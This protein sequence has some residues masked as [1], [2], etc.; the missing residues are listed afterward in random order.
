MRRVALLLCLGM[1]CAGGRGAALAAGETFADPFAYCA[2]VGT[3]DAPDARYTGARMPESI[4]RGLKQAL[5]APAGA[6]L[7]PF[8][9]HSFW[10]CMDGQVYAC[11]V[12]ANIPC[13]E[14]ADTSGTPTAA[15]ADFCRS[16]PGQDVIRVRHRPRHRLPLALRR[17]HPADRPHGHHR[18][19]AR[20]SGERLASDPAARI[21]V[22]HCAAPPAIVTDV[23]PRR[24]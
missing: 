24:R 12:G 14:K 22:R 11:T 20:L 7:T 21:R 8:L 13:Q 16:R 18:R 15:M 19:P 23:S 2:A 5:G 3:I 9:E 17:R 10:R 1:L 6:P 4:A